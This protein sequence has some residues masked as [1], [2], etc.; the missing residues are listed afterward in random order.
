MVSF[1]NCKINLGL[2]I[3]EKRAD[4]YHNLETIFYP[5]NLKD[6]IEIIHSKKFE[7]NI[8]GL[9]VD[10]NESDNL[11][12]KAYHLLKKDFP[13]LPD[14]KIW[15]HKHIPMGAGLGGGSAD[16]AFTLKL[17]NDRFHLNLSSNQ[18]IGYASQLGSDCP[19]FILNKPSFA[20]GRGE[21]LELINLD[22][23]DY[24]FVLIYPGIH[25]STNWA[26]SQIK[27]H[28]STKNLKEIIQLPTELWKQELKNDFEEPVLKKYA[29]LNSIKEK[30]YEAGAL[31]V[32]MTG[33]GSAFYGIFKKNNVPAISLSNNFKTFVA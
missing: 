11:C 9:K 19:F 4:G 33:S 13:S 23:S 29:E 21:I 25:I 6:V 30:L 24:S 18:L 8:S 20:T 7:F 15:L 16:G 27:P 2:H 32:S 10:G 5:I 26:F 3:T 1:P 28:S 22:L 14:I 17:I 31:Y 12:S